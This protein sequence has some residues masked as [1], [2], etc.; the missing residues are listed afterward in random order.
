M[1]RIVFVVSLAMISISLF[2]QP[3]NRSVFVHP[4]MLHSAEDLNRIRKNVADK[5][6][7]WA[8]AWTEF[9][10]SKWLADDYQPRPL[11]IVGR[12]VGSVGQE[13]IQND[14]SAAYY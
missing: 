3:A 6:E 7:P 13:N 5:N 14:C 2:S 10:K 12:G 4:G 1:R 9:L 8:S 11:E